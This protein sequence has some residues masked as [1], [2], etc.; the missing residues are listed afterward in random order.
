MNRVLNV[1][2]SNHYYRRKRRDGRLKGKSK[3]R[4][5]LVRIKE[6]IAE[7]SSYGYRRIAAKIEPHNGLDLLG[8]KGYRLA[9]K[10]VFLLAGGVEV[11][12]NM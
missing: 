11:A 4:S 9:I 2:R 6:V 1:N 5:L 7:R 3:D 10:M 12:F 8:K